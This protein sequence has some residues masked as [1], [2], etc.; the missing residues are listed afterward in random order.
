MQY[1]AFCAIL[2]A[3]SHAKTNPSAPNA[4]ARK[5]SPSRAHKPSASR[6]HKPSA[7]AVKARACKPSPSTATPRT[8]KANGTRKDVGARKPSARRPDT[9]SFGDLY[10]L[11]GGLAA[12]W[13]RKGCTEREMREFLD[14]DPFVLCDVVPALH[15]LG[16]TEEDVVRHV[17][18]D[19]PL[20]ALALGFARFL[21]NPYGRGRATLALPPWVVLAFLRRAVTR[22]IAA[23]RNRSARGVHYEAEKVR[24]RAM[25]A[26]RRRIA[27]RTTTSPCPSKEAL[28]E[29]WRHV[30]DSKEALV[31]FGSMMQDLECYVDNS[32]RFD[33]A[34]RIVGRNAGVKGWL[35]ENAPEIAAHYTSAIRYKA[36]AKKLRQIVGLADPTPVAE[37]LGTKGGDAAQGQDSGDG[38]LCNHGAEKLH[39]R[40]MASLG[41]A[42]ERGVGTDE[43]GAEDSPPVEV[44]RARAVYL[45]VMEGVPDVAARVMAR[46]DALC[47]PDRTDEAATL[48]SWREKYETAI[49]VRRKNSWWRRLTA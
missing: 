30:R 12:V 7:S 37:V 36:A 38:E 18:H 47:D 14:D 11:S 44:V 42:G 17:P 1:A 2:P 24:R 26:E 33:R 22:R 46:I 9:P 48:R 28:L 49:T 29:A 32:L 13:R 25:A 43:D 23:L 8:Q 6:A 41:N 31:R 5:L 21:S 45:E 3:M 19:G 16:F 4:R 15:A 20:A 34:G 27:R 35:A 40:D 39:G 10:E